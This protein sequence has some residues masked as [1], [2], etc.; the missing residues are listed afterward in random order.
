[1][2]KTFFGALLVCA[3]S[4]F[5]S[6]GAELKKVSIGYA[7]NLWFA[8]PAVI[9]GEGWDR[10]MGLD[11]EL[12]RFAGPN[13]ILQAFVSGQ[14]DVMYNN[15]A[16][17]MTPP[18]R[19]FPTRVIASTIKDDIF[20]AARSPLASLKG[21]G[22]AADAIR[23][24]VTQHKRK[25]KIST[26]PK[27]SLSDLVL[28][29]WLDHAFDKP[30]DFVEVINTGSQ[31]QFQQS[32]LSR[33]VDASSIFEPLYT[34]CTRLDRDITLF[35]QPG[36]LMPDMPG[37]A[38][39]VPLAYAQKNPEVVRKLALLNERATRFMQEHPDRA[40]RHV[41]RYFGSTVGADVY[42]TSIRFVRDRL[43]SDPYKMVSSAKIMHQYMRQTG[44]LSRDVNV[45]E[46]Y[47]IKSIS[48]TT[49][50]QK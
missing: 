40:A 48:P 29:Y 27:G 41:A 3:V 7:A 2:K 19:D 37:G 8:Q 25:V 44:Y 26:N 5:L 24:F 6:Q 47:D 20:L 16:A 1:M 9:K 15:I 28:R 22:T 38:V 30:S 12:K 4:S 43:L 11:I 14:C 23:A 49:A 50:A 17:T 46:L 39:S 18:T 36:E 33:D 10:E 31:D 32:I 13:Y 34:I 45:D 42:E 35:A 21:K